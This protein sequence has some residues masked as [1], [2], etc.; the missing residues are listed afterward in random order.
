MLRNRYVT[1]RDL[2]WAVMSAWREYLR[3]KA[4]RLRPA[5][6]YSEETKALRTVSRTRTDL[7]AA[8][9]AA[10]NQLAALL[11]AHWPGAKEV[12]ADVASP[13]GVAFLTRYP[14]PASA[15]NLDVKRM[16]AFCARHAY[17]GRRSPEALLE[18]MR[19]A[20][21]GSTGPVLTRAMREAVL[22]HVAVLA[23]LNTAIKSLDRSVAGH[24]ADHP[25]GKVFASFPRCRRSTPRR[26]SP[27]GGIPATH[28]TGP[29]PWPPSADWC[30]SPAPPANIA[31]STSDGHVITPALRCHHLRRQQSA[32]KPLGRRYLPTRPCQRQGSPARSPDSCSSLGAGYL[33]LLAHRHALRLCASQRR[34][35]TPR[36]G[37]SGLNS[38]PR[39]DTEDVMGPPACQEH[40][41][42]EHRN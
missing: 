25:D 35:G 1:Y 6:P 29:T 5:V 7:V 14:T 37:G 23:A 2:G 19:N 16:A 26:S 10:T 24:L 32:R 18:R 41:T 30:R 13:I 33:A 11:D 9:V 34:A 38:Q 31:A 3:L 20:A 40:G 27:S 12:F 36:R 28:V 39:V 15:A 42:V 8:R 17:S 21:G 4:R 22:A